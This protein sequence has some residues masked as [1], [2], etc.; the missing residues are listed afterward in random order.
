VYKRVVQMPPCDGSSLEAPQDRHLLAPK[1]RA[2]ELRTL[3]GKR[4]EKRSLGTK[5]PVEAKRLHARALA[6]VESRWASL[7]AGPRPL[8]EREA[9]ALA[10]EFHDRWLESY[11]DNPSQQTIWRIDLFERM[12]VAAP[13][14]DLTAST[15]LIGRS[16]KICPV[17]ASRKHGVSKV[18]RTCLLGRASSWT[19]RASCSSPRR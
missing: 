10:A 15:S 4:E 1:R 11:R 17:C 12:W 14:D 3:V 7:R 5:D 19:M 18:Q 13:L 8:T 9:H 16:I 6:E 2:E